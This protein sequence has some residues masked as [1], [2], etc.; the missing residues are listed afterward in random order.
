MTNTVEAVC[1]MPI[2]FAERGD[3]SMVNL[4]SE[5]GYCEHRVTV[6][7]AALQ[8]HLRSEPGLVDVWL[9]F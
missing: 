4:L 6:N 2:S 5:S 8:A 9:P 1:R 7:E 3:V